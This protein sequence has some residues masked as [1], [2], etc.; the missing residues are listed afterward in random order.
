VLDTFVIAS[1]YSG[2]TEEALD[3][4]RSA[5]E[6]GVSRAVIAA[7]GMLLEGG[8]QAGV[9][10]VQL[11]EGVPPRMA[12]VAGT[13][14]LLALLG[15]DRGLKEIRE[16]ENTT[17]GDLEHT[18]AER[19]TR[20]AGMIPIIYSSNRNAELAYIWKI[21]LNETGKIPAFHNIFP[22]ANH[23]E[24]EGLAGDD[25]KFRFI[26]LVDS[27]DDLRIQKRMAVFERMMED[28]AERVLLNEGTTFR[29]IFASIL[30]ASWTAYYVAKKSGAEPEATPTIEA[31]KK[32]M[33]EA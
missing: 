15:E 14:A 5:G 8:R 23:N 18:G 19:A 17:W 32:Q 21:M 7:G 10:C 3:A 16:M 27:E 25:R 24:I 4:F 11:P 2:N 29:G 9:P 12:V 30:E 33:K 31:F 28:R 22:E 26:L 6:R 20:L 13:I 1:S